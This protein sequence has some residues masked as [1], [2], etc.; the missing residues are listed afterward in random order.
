MDTAAGNVGSLYALAKAAGVSD[1]TLYSYRTRDSEPNRAILI[2]LAMA[3]GVSVE[4]LATG[5][6]PISWDPHRLCDV[7][8]TIEE[9]LRQKRR[10]ISIGPKAQLIAAV[11]EEIA[12][13]ERPQAGEPV[14]PRTARIV[15]IVEK[16]AA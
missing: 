15:K 11:Y 1:Q 6:E 12:H 8:E 7:I 2:K 10:R 9:W 5:R 13:Q 14:E 3:A 4:W 16:R